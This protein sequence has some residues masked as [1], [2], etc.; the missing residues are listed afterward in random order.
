MLR[1]GAAMDAHAC[2]HTD[3]DGKVL[4]LSAAATFWS[5]VHESRFLLWCA[6]PQQHPCCSR[7][8]FH[9]SYHKVAAQ[10]LACCGVNEADSPARHLNLNPA[11]LQVAQA[12]RASSDGMAA[13]LSR[14]TFA[15]TPCWMAPEVME[16]GQPC[17]F[18]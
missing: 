18:P 7:S 15:G 16:D 6:L 13:Y 9:T 8:G 11:F 17:V 14:T 5:R 12:H 2:L 3:P 4:S 10:R 1:I